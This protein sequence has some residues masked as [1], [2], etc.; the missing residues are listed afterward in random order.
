[1]VERPWE[2]ES[3]P[4]HQYPA[5]LS[6]GYHVDIVGGEVRLLGRVPF[7]RKESIINDKTSDHANAVQRACVDIVSS[8]FIAD[9]WP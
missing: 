8:V 1:M 9:A 2:C 3:P 7:W 4:A 6:V 5:H